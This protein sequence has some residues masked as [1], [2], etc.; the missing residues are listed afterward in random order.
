MPFFEWLSFQGIKTD[1]HK[2]EKQGF[3]IYIPPK[4]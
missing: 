2:F 3:T 1:A 4:D